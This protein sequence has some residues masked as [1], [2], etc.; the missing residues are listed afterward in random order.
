MYTPKTNRIE[1]KAATRAT[2]REAA[3]GSFE[4][5]GYRE[6]KIADITGAAGVAVG[7]FH[8]HFKNKD[9]LLDELLAEFNLGL[10]EKVA[11]LV[12]EN[13]A[14]DD[15]ATLHRFAI[16]FLDHWK[17]NRPFIAAYA[18][19]AGGGLS[20]MTLRDGANPPMY[21]LL[22]TLLRQRLAKKSRA[23]LIAHGLLAL[24]LRL[25]LQYVFGQ[26][27]S[28]DEIATVLVEMTL[29]AIRGSIGAKIAKKQKR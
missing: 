24:W 29:G 3:L 9:E 16:I 1:Q 17:A 13:P 14:I 25:G 26:K 22:V 19:K 6:T 28:R 5:H 21:D 7:T 2:L 11:P 15:P 18:Q 23:H 4:K 12:A 10:V 8:V 27:L 20:I